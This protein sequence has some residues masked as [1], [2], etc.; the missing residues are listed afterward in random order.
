[1]DTPLVA[2]I[3]VAGTSLAVAV[4]C[5]LLAFLCRRH[6][7]SK[8]QLKPRCC[9]AAASTLR[10][11]APAGTTPADCPSWSFYGTAADA[12]LL[13]LSLADLAAATGGFSPDNIIGDGSFGFVYRAVLPDGAAVAVKRL[14]GDGDAG[15]GNREFRAELEVLG[16]LSHPNL[17]RLLGYCAAGRDRIL[18]YELLERG[19]L[20]AWLHGGDAVDGGGTKTLPWS[21]R[22]C[23]ARGVAAA[24]DFLHHG[25]RPPVLHRDIKSSNVLLGEG[26]EAKLADFGLARIVRGSPAKSHVSTQAAGTAGYVAPEIWDGVGATAKAD[27][28]SFGV[29]VIE[30]V[31]GLRPSWPMKASMGDKEVNLVDWARDKIGAGLASEILDR[32]MGIPAQGKEMEEAKGLL[33]IARRCIDSAA[34]NRPTMEEA[35][36][37]LSKI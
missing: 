32:R 30:L 24:L 13:K 35:V 37:M 36:A 3:V 26:F 5:L 19:S 6:S 4:P 9:L 1:M 2:L 8:S 18:V 27:V 23:V 22:L 28:Y 31:T 25:R 29:L 7:S 10:V 20:D 15:A 21:A 34:K 12:S 17:A 16:S 11:S 33:E 14:S